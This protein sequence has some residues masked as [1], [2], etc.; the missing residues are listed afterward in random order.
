MTIPTASNFPLSFDSD[1]NLFLVHDSL[2]VRLL[3]D[4][5][6]GNTSILIEGDESII[7]KFPPTGIIT[8]TEQCSD[9]DQ[10]A[11]SL[12]YNSRTT[13]SFDEL[14]ILDEFLQKDWIQ[15]VVKPKRITNVTMNVLDKHHNHLKDT[16]ISVETFLGTVH[17]SS[18]ED[19][20][21]RISYL[22]NLIFTPKA[23]FTCDKQI[24]LIQ[25]G[26]LEV[27][28]TNESFRLG[29]GPITQ[30][31][32]FSKK[33]TLDGTYSL[34]ETRTVISETYA[35][36]LEE[37]IQTKT[38][39]SPGI[40]KVS[41][42]M[43]NDFGN[44]TVVFDELINVKI[45][46][47]EE[48]LI[49]I[50]ARTSQNYT[51][52]SPIGGPYVQFP[53]IRSIANSFID[54][55]IPSGENPNN[56]G[57][58]YAG[59]L[60]SGGSPIDSIIEYTWSLGDDLVHSNSN[61]TRAS[62]GMGGY[63]S[64]VIRVDTA[65]GAYRIT[66]Y[67][68]SIDI[69]ESK[70]LWLFNF[71]SQNSN[72]SGNVQAYEFG[73]TS[74]T[75]KTLGNNTQYIDRNN[76]FLNQYDSDDYYSGTFL[77]SKNEF[78]RNVEFVKSGTDSSG[79]R[80]N[81]L[82]FWASG[83]SSSDN[84]NILVR[85]YNAFDDVYTNLSNISNRPWNWVA[86]SSKEKTYFLFGQDESGI[87]NQNLAFSQRLDFDLASQ[88][89]SAPVSLSIS[90]FE[91]G[92]DEL[93][94]HPSY[95]SEGIA[96]NGYFSIY[97]SAWKDS[98]G[99]VLRNSAVNEFFRISSFYKTKGNL[100]SPFNTL[101]KLPDMIGPIKTE[102]QLVPMYNGIFMF[103][104]SGEISAWNDTSLTWEVGRA[105]ASSVSFRTIQDTGVSSF[106]DKSNTLLA[107]SDEDRIAYLSFDYSDK[108]FIK[109][110]GTDLTFT[111]TKYRPA[112]T[113]FKMGIY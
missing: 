113:Q 24:G 47:P 50:N 6:Y 83:G 71:T 98:T 8:L 67:E 57:Y 14:E 100:S 94:Q 73:L 11:I 88:S 108:T 109:F 89:A 76:S 18:K 1:Q 4:Y 95:F 29:E 32:E 63:Y 102:G 40:Y 58:S 26:M 13:S 104:N 17:S 37:K 61:F 93:L 23:W 48:A 2:R 77:K 42:T 34:D 86:L 62:Y 66:K 87:E 21:G 90:D 51:A 33:N 79:E 85:N 91:N 49:N 39:S 111:T 45:E 10:R 60:L 3:E 9:I 46:C 55:E 96:T 80:G 97:R 81:S 110:N 92:A 28:F 5:N 68:N 41:L 69:I 7:S 38:F 36:F 44:D 70:N 27:N 25:D 105:N 16:L 59:E 99:Y 82:L 74:E 15:N 106:D 22:E 84:K 103:N 43:T 75:F 64:I 107:T 65:F 78:F 72:S 20:T 31:W 54:L 12:Y 56:P 19:L 35:N 52:G 101:T 53:K 112:G 30:V